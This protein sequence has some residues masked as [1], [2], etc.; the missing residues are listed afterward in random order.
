[1]SERKDVKETFE[2]KERRGLLNVFR[3]EEDLHFMSEVDAAIHRKGS[4]M[5]FILTLV[6]ALLMGTFVVWAHF[7]VLDEVTRGMGQVI[8]SQKVQVIQNLEGG[9]LQEILVQENQIV[10]KGDILIRIDNA[11][12]ASQYR[13]AFTKAAEHEAAILRLNAE[14]DRK[15]AIVFPDQF[16]DADPQVLEDQRSIFKARRQQL[17]AEINVLRSQH[18]QKQQEIAEMKSR[19]EQLERSLGLAKEQRDISKPL[20]DQGVYPR[21]EYLA[22]ERDISSL[23]GD[24]DAL[25][26]AVPRIRQAANEANRRIE[27]RQ[28]EFKTEALNEMNRRR[29]ELKSLR[30]IMSAGEDR[31]TRT[32]VRS[33][34]RGTIKQINLNTIGGVVRPG[35]P[36]LEIVPLDDTLLIEARIRPAD[37]AFLHPG[38]KA[39]VKI[40]A[41]DFS[42]FGGLEGVV[43]AISADTI[44]D[45]N[46]ESFFKVK[47]RTQNNA[48]IYRNEELPIIP[49]MTASIDIL[50]GKKSVLAYLLKPI[51]RAKQN[52][53]RER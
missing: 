16:K 3:E 1:M 12:A 36:I 5:A 2:H 33:P 31:V 49:G 4:S 52:A 8:P 28:A 20:V 18:S 21:V 7:T 46:G 24:I 22:L 30:E 9:I 40:T 38:Q 50:T 14:I 11:L 13:D 6:I 32:D 44:E 34:V 37:I 27:Q 25:R 47:L 29:G 41:Y 45:D 23:Q 35:E 19:R 53:L 17:Q 43:E 42:I 48:I 26:M 15:A 39:M 10:N 51:L